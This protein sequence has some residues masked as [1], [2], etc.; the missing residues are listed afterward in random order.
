M[1]TFIPGSISTPRGFHADVPWRSAS[2]PSSRSDSRTAAYTGFGVRAT[3]SPPSS[4]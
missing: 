4:G 3:G 2:S 1:S